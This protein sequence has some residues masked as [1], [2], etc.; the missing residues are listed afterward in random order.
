ML[1]GIVH[2]KHFIKQIVPLFSALAK[3]LKRGRHA[4]RTFPRHTERV[5]KA[6]GTDAA[7]C[8]FVALTTIVRAGRAHQ[9]EAV[10]DPI[11]PKR[12]MRF[13]SQQR[14]LEPHLTQP[15]RAPTIRISAP[16]SCDCQPF[17]TEARARFPA[18]P[19]ERQ[20][21]MQTNPLH[22]PP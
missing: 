18:S 7:Y 16:I 6:D 4:K 8:C 5:D 11:P 13:R 9:L 21:P 19:T 17:A 3:H 12:R 10:L 14:A 2:S 15:D 1:I 20:K 22:A